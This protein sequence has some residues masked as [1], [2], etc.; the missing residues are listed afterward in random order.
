MIRR[1]RV[2]VR[3]RKRMRRRKA[4]RMKRRKEAKTRRK[5]EVAKTKK[6]QATARMTKKTAE[7]LQQ[8]KVV[9]SDL[10]TK[11]SQPAV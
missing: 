6:R 7:L 8:C 10:T 1:K 3:I 4:P 2:A 9:S 11:V 5:K